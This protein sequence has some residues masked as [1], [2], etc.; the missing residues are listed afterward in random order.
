MPKHRLGSMGTPV[1]VVISGKPVFLCC[2]GCREKALADPDGTL[3]KAE[4][5]KADK[6][7]NAE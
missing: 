5:L 7:G 4:K 2:E 6:D 1:K 3:A